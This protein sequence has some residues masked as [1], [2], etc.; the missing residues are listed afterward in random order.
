MAV[1]DNVFTL[2]TNQSVAYT[3]T[4]G[5]ITNAVGSQTRAVRVVTTTAAFIKIGNSPTATT[6]DV[7]MPAGLPEIFQI[8]PGMKVSA[9]QVAAGGSLYV[10]ELDH[11]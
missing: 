4:A 6:S 10:T 3:G 2:G 1:R 9:V 8:S 11:G 7:Y 5:T